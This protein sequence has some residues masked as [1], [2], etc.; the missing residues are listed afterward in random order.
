MSAGRWSVTPGSRQLNR[1]TIKLKPRH[2]L[3]GPG[4]H[5]RMIE[6]SFTVQQLKY[7]HSLVL[8]EVDRAAR[9]EN[10]EYLPYTELSLQLEYLLSENEVTQ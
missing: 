9:E 1:S 6:T 4:D 7:L 8:N 5:R 10:A 2:R 3:T